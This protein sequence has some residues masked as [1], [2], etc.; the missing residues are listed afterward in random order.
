ITILDPATAGKIKVNFTPPQTA[1]IFAEIYN[2]EIEIR[3]DDDIKRTVIR[4][5][6]E[7]LEDIIQW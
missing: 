6:F 1:P 5:Q 2:F 4:E 3:K 7:V